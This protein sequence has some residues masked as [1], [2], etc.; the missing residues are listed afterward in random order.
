[1]EATLPVDRIYALYSM[2]V[3][4]GLQ[5]PEPDYDKPYQFVY[6]VIWAY[7]QSQQDLSILQA[8]SEPL[9]YCEDLPSW[10]PSFHRT[11]K[12]FYSFRYTSW[13]ILEPREN[14]YAGHTEAKHFPR[15][16]QVKGICMGK[17]TFM[18]D[19]ETYKVWCRHVCHHST[20]ASLGG[21]NASYE[22]VLLD[23]FQTLMFPA[24]AV[25]AVPD[26]YD[27]GYAVFRTWIDTYIKPSPNVEDFDDFSYDN[28][29]C[30]KVV[31]EWI[32]STLAKRQLHFCYL[33]LDNDMIGW[34]RNWCDYGDEV[35]LLRGADCPFILR[36]VRENYRLI[37]SAYLPLLDKMQPWQFDGEDVQTITLI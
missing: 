32:D 7:I 4:C 8:A 1:M 3:K 2:L 11:F 12:S 30:P 28:S 19:D 35:F 13:D 14:P 25:P 22:Q 33:L 6:E 37:S 36:K 16:L 9:E 23:M 24:S 20:Q 34:A 27:N 21:Y 5:L 10:V 15:M 17:V 18:K 29:L 31:R 26:G